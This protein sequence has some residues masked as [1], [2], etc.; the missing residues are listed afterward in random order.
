MTLKRHLIAAMVGVC[1]ASLGHAQEV[2]PPSHFPTS[3][4]ASAWIEADPSVIRAR[5]QAEA[6]DH[7]GAAVAASPNEWTVR[8]DAQRRRYADTGVNSAEWTAQIERTLRINGKAG[9]DRQL[10]DIEA[11][12]GLA[13]IGEARHEAARALADL[14]VD[15]I[16]AERQRALLAE[17]V[18]FA[19]DSLD[20]VRKRKQ[21]GDASTLDV[22][23]AQADLGDVEREA[24]LAATTLAKAEAALRARFPDAVAAASAL[25]EPQPPLWTE[26]EWHER[27][28][29]ESDALRTA[30]REWQKSRVAAERSRADRVPDPTVGIFAASEARRN[31]KIIGVSVSIPL[32]GTYRRERMLQAQKEADTAEASLEQMRRSAV[33]AATGTWADATGSLARWRLSQQTARLAADN[34]R[35]MQKAYALGE[36]DLQS[37]LLARRQFLETSRAALAAQGEAVRAQMRVLIDA[38][39]IW[40]LAQ[41]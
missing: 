23:I 24:S 37:L 31:E 18:A 38:H 29:A 3:E 9:L 5:R 39:L 36:A 27:A 12:I 15:A 30:Q 6:A 32:S 4:K 21:A 19:A 25:P 7:G 16:V 11:S 40:N 14:W 33:L 8:V 13:R 20:A 26:A 22:N 41:E 10:R 34:A 28:I 2:A 17:Q 35:L 1:V